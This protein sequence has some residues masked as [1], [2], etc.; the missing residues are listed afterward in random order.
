[1]V[2]SNNLLLGA[3]SAAAGDYLIEQSLLFDD[4]SATYLSRTPSTV[5]NRKTWT[6]SVWVKRGVLT[7]GT[8]QRQFIFTAYNPAGSIGFD[9]EFSLTD[10]ITFYIYNST[11]VGQLTTSAKYRDPSAWYHI[12]IAVDT[13]QATASNRLKLYV[14]GMQITDLATATY[15]SH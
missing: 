10:E 9:L 3:V 12:V 8:G 5:G 2:F 15:P 7:N 1:M 6:F 11:A 4:S 13:T 14:N